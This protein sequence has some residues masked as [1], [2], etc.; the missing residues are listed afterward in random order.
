ME[1]NGLASEL[2]S[3]ILGR[4]VKPARQ[5][6]RTAYALRRDTDEELQGEEVVNLPPDVQPPMD[7]TR[8]SHV[9][10]KKTASKKTADE[11]TTDSHQPQDHIPR[12]STIRPAKPDGPVVS[13]PASGRSAAGSVEASAVTVSRVLVV[14]KSDVVPARAASKAVMRRSPER[15]EALVELLSEA[16]EVEVGV[17]LAELLGYGSDALPFVARSFPGRL[18][19]Q[20]GEQPRNLP[21]GAKAGAAI[22]ALACAFLRFGEEAV[23]HLELLRTSPAEQIRRSAEHVLAVLVRG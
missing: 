6:S 16:D 23:P 19:Q 3:L 18:W 20:P 14:R 11:Q 5:P 8:D 15:L 17:L 22:S 1:H 7:A 9:A 2:L 12:H 21:H 13:V 4:M 10:H